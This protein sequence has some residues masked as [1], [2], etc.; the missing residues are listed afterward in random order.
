[1]CLQTLGPER[2]EAFFPAGDRERAGQGFKHLPF[3]QLNR[4]DVEKREAAWKALQP[5]QEEQSVRDLTFAC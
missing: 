5:G 1:M 3:L 4:L 2:D